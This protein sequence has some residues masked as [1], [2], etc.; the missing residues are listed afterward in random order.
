MLCAA[1][2]EERTG[3]AVPV[4]GTSP[5]SASETTS[6]LLELGASEHGFV[7]ARLLDR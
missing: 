6:E 5:R 3:R 1:G 2:G 7:I 4:H